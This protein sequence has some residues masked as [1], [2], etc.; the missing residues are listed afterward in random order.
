MS[1][2]ATSAAS[3][4]Q[5]AI[6]NAHRLALAIDEMGEGSAMVDE[7]IAILANRLTLKDIEQNIRETHDE[8]AP[9]STRLDTRSLKPAAHR[10]PMAVRFGFV[11]R[12][13]TAVALTVALSGLSV[14][15]V[16]CTQ[17]ARAGL[18]QAPISGVAHAPAAAAGATP[19][20]TATGAAM[21]PPPGVRR[22]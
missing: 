17:T 14:A 4:D 12:W 11:R 1:A 16:R 7:I 2:R 19:A 20:A 15:I 3:A 10:G 6:R 13:F 5:Q 9:I 8:F 18:P 22:P 21:P